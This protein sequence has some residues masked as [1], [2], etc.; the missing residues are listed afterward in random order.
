MYENLMKDLRSLG[1]QWLLTVLVTIFGMQIL[2]VLFV[3]FVGYLRDSQGMASL[4][5]APIAIGIFALSFLAGPVKRLAGNAKRHL[6]F[7]RW[8]GFGALN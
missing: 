1:K 7:C 2:R 8:I 4:T 3:G 6:D 5:L